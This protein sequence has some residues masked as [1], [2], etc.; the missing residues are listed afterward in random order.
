[1]VHFTTVH[2]V[3]FPFMSESGDCVHRKAEQGRVMEME[4][5]HLLNEEPSEAREVY[6]LRTGHNILGWPA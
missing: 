3:T 2:C 5:E 1:M 6:M 4:G